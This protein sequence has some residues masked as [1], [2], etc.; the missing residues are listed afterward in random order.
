[1]RVSLRLKYLFPPVFFNIKILGI[2]AMVSVT[3]T[4]YKILGDT[5]ADDARAFTRAELYAYM[6]EKTQ[7]WSEG[8]V[9]HSDAGTH[10]G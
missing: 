6:S 9:F 2:I 8:R 10:P 4:S 7:V 1:M 3:M 5:L